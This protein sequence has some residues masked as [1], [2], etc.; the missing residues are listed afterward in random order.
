MITYNTQVMKIMLDE[1]A[2]RVSGEKLK[3]IKKE[4]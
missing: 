3:F 2:N 1:G 4:G